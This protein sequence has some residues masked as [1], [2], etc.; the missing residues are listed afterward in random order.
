MPVTLKPME[1]REPGY[2]AHPLSRLPSMVCLVAEM[3]QM[4]VLSARRQRYAQQ[5]FTSLPGWKER[6]A[7]SAER[8]L[9]LRAV[10]PPRRNYHLEKNPLVLTTRKNQHTRPATAPRAPQQAANSLDAPELIYDVCAKRCDEML[11]SIR[12]AQRIMNMRGA[13]AQ[14]PTTA[15]S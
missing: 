6:C 3:E 5:Q 10:P 12:E 9:Q 13:V 2:I 11:A 4:R 14:L 15:E 1:Q 7:K 8:V